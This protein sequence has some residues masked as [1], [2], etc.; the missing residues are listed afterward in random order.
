[1]CTIEQSMAKNNT[2]VAATTTEA[3]TKPAKTVEKSKPASK[4]KQ[5]AKPTGGAPLEQKSTLKP[6]VAKTISTAKTVPTVSEQEKK[7]MRKRT[8]K[9]SL[10]DGKYCSRITGQTPKQAASKALTLI[11]NQTLAS[12]QKPSKGKLIFKIRETTRG[13]KQKE[14]SYQGEK[15]KLKVPTTYKIH[16]AN[17]D[18]KEIVNRF[19]NVIE[20]Y[21]E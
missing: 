8:F 20:K 4:A 5:S 16:A 1:M 21:N 13:S 9:I 18:V 11:I 19:K 3:V 14:Y 2:T 17:G 6:S 12:G 15:V 10:G 7:I